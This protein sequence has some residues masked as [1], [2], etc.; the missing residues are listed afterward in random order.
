MLFAVF[1]LALELVS[2]FSFSHSFTPDTP[3]TVYPGET[4][5]LQI[6][7][8]AN[9]DEGSLKIRAELSEGKEI[10]SL[11]DS[12]AE[13]DVSSSSWAS[14]NIK[15]K[16]PENASNG[17]TIKVRFTDITPSEDL[18]TVSFK[19][20]SVVTLPVTVL[21]KP[22]PEEEIRNM[23]KRPALDRQTIFHQS[24]KNFL[25]LSHS[26]LD[27]SRDRDQLVTPMA[28]R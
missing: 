21:E 13:Y 7:L 4:K 9:P 18:G 2:G 17:Y 15:L 11:I 25:G 26:L 27:E 10:A 28:K 23:I 14:V 6:Q 3:L 20:G 19:G 8:N 5:G 24:F 16:I 22:E 12:V 1:F